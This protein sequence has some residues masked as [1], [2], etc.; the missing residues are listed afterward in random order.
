MAMPG[1]VGRENRGNLG[2]WVLPTHYNPSQN[3]EDTYRGGEA[4]QRKVVTLGFLYS[5][6]ETRDVKSFGC[7]LK[8]WLWIH[9][10]LGDIR[11]QICESHQCFV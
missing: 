6:D 11:R 2:N 1:C 7:W 5:G 3:S 4:G 8:G 9:G 10:G